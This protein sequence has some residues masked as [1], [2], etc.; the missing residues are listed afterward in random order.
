MQLF[1]PS[2]NFIDYTEMLTQTIVIVNPN[3]V[4]TIPYSPKFLLALYFIIIIII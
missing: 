2:G 4:R 1:S 3:K